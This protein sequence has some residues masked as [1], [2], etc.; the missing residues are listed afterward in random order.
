MMYFGSMQK[1]VEA[2]PE[3]QW[4]DS[5]HRS[6][7][8]CPDAHCRLLQPAAEAQA[9]ADAAVAAAEAQ[10]A[11]AAPDAPAEVLPWLQLSFSP[12]AAAVVAGSGLVA[13]ACWG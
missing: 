13:T 3:L 7:I 11:M 8:L 12:C 1:L 5:A 6:I 4:E 9:A 2:T 10:A